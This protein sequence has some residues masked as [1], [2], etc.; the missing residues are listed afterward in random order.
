MILTVYG[1][2]LDGATPTTNAQAVPF[3]QKLSVPQG[4]DGQVN[5]IVLN[6][7]GAAVNIGAGS[8]VL[9]V[10]NRYTDT[11]SPQISRAGVIDSGAGGLAHFSLVEADT[12]APSTLNVGPCQY[13]IWWTD[14]SGVRH[15]LVPVSDFEILPTVGV[16]GSPTTAPAAP[17]GTGFTNEGGQAFTVGGSASILVT[18]AS[19]MAN[20]SYRVFLSVG[21]SSAG[22]IPNVS[23][24]VVSTTTFY[25]DA[26]GAFDGIVAWGAR[27]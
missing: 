14:G 12:V 26:S 3:A 9:T 1:V 4:C 22:E 21:R 24:R 8:L 27:P 10:K 18:M 15:Q 5:L 23:Y 6:P 20:T 25:I 11:G 19:P 17:T 13:D 7:A 2:F 16:P